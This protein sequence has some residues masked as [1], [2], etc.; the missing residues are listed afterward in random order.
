[1]PGPGG[2]GGMGS[3]CLMGTELHVRKEKNSGDE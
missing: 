1:M 2:G 3:S